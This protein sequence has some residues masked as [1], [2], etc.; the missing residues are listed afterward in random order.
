MLPIVV[1]RLVRSGSKVWA[2]AFGDKRDLENLGR[3][4]HVDLKPSEG[5]K[6]I[7]LDLNVKQRERAIRLGAYEEE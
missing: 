1:T 5:D 2:N 6:P 4:L 7:H 3:R